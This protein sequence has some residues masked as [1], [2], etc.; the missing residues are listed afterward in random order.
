MTKNLKEKY[1]PLYFL[2][3]LGAGGLSVS[4]FMYL[5]FMIPHKGTPMVTF[6]HWSDMLSNSALP[7]QIGIV[8]VLLLQIAL[9]VLHLFLL[10]WNLKEF[11]A[12]KRTP[13]YEAMKQTPQAISILALPLTLAMT[14]NVVLIAGALY[15]PGLWN[16]IEYLFPVSL[17][18]FSLVGV[19]ALRIFGDYITKVISE[20]DPN[21]V[22]ANNLSS[23][24]SI[25]TF[26]MISV[27]YAASGAMSHTTAVNAIGL[28]M[29]LFFGIIAILLA[30]FKFIV[31]ARN[32]FENGIAKEASPTL[33]IIIPFLTLI[34]I[35]AVRFLFGLNHHYETPLP[36]A[37]L[38]VLTSGIFALQV[39]AGLVGYRVMKRIGYFEEY[40]SGSKKSP[41]SFSLICP[42]VA[43]FVFGFFFIHFGIVKNGIIDKYSWAYFAVMLPFVIIQLKTVQ[44]FIRLN[45]KLLFS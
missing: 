13:A 34:G 24:L 33:W 20:G 1:S 28:F 41:G 6:S 15:I 17:V 23:L 43:F 12:F 36:N 39:A 10:Y 29:A 21:F 38:F 3:S 27:G 30:L 9:G 14:L 7:L 35:T 44:V 32:I 22:N 26:S 31:G 11:F 16:Y 18:G 45:V 8:S 25:F 2:A 40:V 5:Q 42:G 37:T 4:F 19:L